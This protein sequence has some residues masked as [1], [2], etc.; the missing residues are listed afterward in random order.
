MGLDCYIVSKDGRSGGG[1][2]GSYTGV[3]KLRFILIMGCIKLCISKINDLYRELMTLYMHTIFR[4][5]VLPISKW[6]V[7]KI[8]SFNN[9][10]NPSLLL[11]DPHKFFE[12]LPVSGNLKFLEEF[13]DNY[14]D[15]IY[16][17]LDNNNVIEQ[18]ISYIDVYKNLMT[19]IKDPDENTDNKITADDQTYDVLYKN[20]NQ[21]FLSEEEHIDKLNLANL[22]GIYKFVQ[23]SDCDGSFS[24]GDC[25]DIIEMIDQVIEYTKEYGRVYEWIDEVRSFYQTAIDERGTL[26]YC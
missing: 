12:K 8:V 6:V 10:E 1:R 20:I 9:I 3:H 15:I 14:Y 17:S 16:N 25:W 5:K 21:Y 4:I 22:I 23:H 18:M 26:V 13:T 24:F 7:E 19:W 11:D 2:I